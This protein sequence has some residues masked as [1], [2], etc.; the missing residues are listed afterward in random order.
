MA[1]WEGAME[2]EIEDR[3]RER[4]F[5]LWET[6]GR[7]EGRD[8]EHWLD[9]ERELGEEAINGPMGMEDDEPVETAPEPDKELRALAE[10]SG[11][12][13]GGDARTIRPEV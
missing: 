7:P 6:E 3:V 11:D 9:A 10:T 8:V 12:A 13:E 5:E 1:N 2:R 4:A